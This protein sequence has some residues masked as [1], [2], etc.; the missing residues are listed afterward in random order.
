MNDML[1]R[2]VTYMLDQYGTVLFILAATITFSYLVV[3]YDLKNQE[4]NATLV[5]VSSEQSQI[6]QG[7][8]FYT[9]QL[10]LYK[11]KKSTS[12]SRRFISKNLARLQDTHLSLKEGDR[13]VREGSRMTHVRGVLPSELRKIY[14]DKGEASLNRQMYRY[15]SAVREILGMPIESLNVKGAQLQTLYHDITPS[16]IVNL[17]TVSSIYQKRMTSMLEGTKRKQN[18]VVI[19]SLGILALLGTGLLRPLVGKL[20]ES[21]LK[22]ETE[23]AFA[24]NVINTAQALIIGLDATGNI[25]LFNQ[26]AEESTGWAKED[27]LGQPFFET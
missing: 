5:R 15:R 20:K 3:I 14:F 18:F 7:I 6:I 11:D 10:A 22:V 12:Q 21:N 26:Y 24:D 17:N 4:G 25:V 1:R 27:V 19:L 23:K 9:T 2:I 13:F 8:N 16:L